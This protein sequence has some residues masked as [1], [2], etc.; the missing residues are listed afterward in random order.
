MLRVVHA[1]CMAAPLAF[2]SHFDSINVCLDASVAAAAVL[3]GFRG[4]RARAIPCA[5]R[6]YDTDGTTVFGCGLTKR[7]IVDST[8]VE[9]APGYPHH[10]VVEAW[11]KGH[12]V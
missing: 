5:V 9:D 3:R 1:L 2:G 11:F 7:E 12:R 8:L 10:V 4:F 6:G